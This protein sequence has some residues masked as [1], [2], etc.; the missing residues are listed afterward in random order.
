MRAIS[1]METLSIAPTWNDL[2]AEFIQPHRSTQ[3]TTRRSVYMHCLARDPPA[4]PFF[5]SS[6]YPGMNSDFVNAGS[7][8]LK[9]VLVHLCLTTSQRWQANKG[10]CVAVSCATKATQTRR[11]RSGGEKKRLSKVEKRLKLSKEEKR[12]LWKWKG[13]VKMFVVCMCMFE[14]E[15]ERENSE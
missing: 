12:Q 6:C 8:E 9:F 14:R 10:F 13:G 11:W 2:Y 5:R 1:L 7:A 15:R 4:T 3:L